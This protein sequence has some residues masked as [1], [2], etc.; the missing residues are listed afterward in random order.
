MYIILGLS[1]SIAIELTAKLGKPV[2]TRVHALA[3][4]PPVVDFH[5]PPDA[6]PKHTIEVSEGLTATQRLMPPTLYGPMDDQKDGAS[7]LSIS[8]KVLLVYSNASINLLLGTSLKGA[9]LAWLIN[10]IERSASDGPFSFSY[11]SAPLFSSSTLIS[12]VLKLPINR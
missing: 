3:P 5:N 11:F 1:E 9:T 2:S 4:K 7:P 10:C 6:E 8:L 12:L